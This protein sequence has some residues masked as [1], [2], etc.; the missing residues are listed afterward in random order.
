M[1]AKAPTDRYQRPAEA[2]EALR[3]FTAGADLARLLDAEGAAAAPGGVS[4]AETATPAPGARET[5]ADGRRRQAPA[6]ARRR[7]LLPALAAL[8]LLTV[9]GFLWL[10][11]GGSSRPAANPLEIKEIRVSHYRDKGKTLVGDLRT[12]PAALRV[13][14]DVRIVAELSAPAYCYLIAFNPDGTV[15]LCHPAGDNGAGAPA[16]PPARGAEVRYPPEAQA[17]VLDSPGLQAFVLAASTKP[18]PPYRAWPPGDSAIPW[19]AVKDGG[20]WRWHFDGHAFAR[21]PRERGRLEAREGVPPPLEKLR[22]FFMKRP[23]FEA[24]QI[25]AFPVGKRQE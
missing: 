3:P 6:R 13:D 7:A 4:A 22:D 16:T 24:I 9:A 25:I 20:A 8:C 5:D 1:L 11:P 18:L 12:S 19:E 10:R 17:F 21:F 2:A 14:D 15:Q 23:E